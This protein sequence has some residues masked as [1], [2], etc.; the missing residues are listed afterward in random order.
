MRAKKLVDLGF[1][2]ERKKSDTT[3]FWVPFLYRDALHLIQGRAG[4]DDDGGDEEQAGDP[5]Q[6]KAPIR[7]APSRSSAAKHLVMNLVVLVY[8][9]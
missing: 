6:L 9:Q 7:L 1:F 8:T 2:E 5:D 4:S 3:T